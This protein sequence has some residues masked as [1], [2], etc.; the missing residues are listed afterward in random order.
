MAPVTRRMVAACGM[1]TKAATMV[2]TMPISL[3]MAQIMFMLL[4]PSSKTISRQPPLPGRQI[5]SAGGRPGYFTQSRTMRCS[6]V[7]VMA[8]MEAP[9]NAAP[10]DSKMVAR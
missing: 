7:M 10:R 6:N 5:F 9:T 8:M 4:S 3:A 2:T 1:V